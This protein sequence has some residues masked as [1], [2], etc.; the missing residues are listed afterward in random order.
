MAST[1][2]EGGYLYISTLGSFAVNEATYYME[3][4]HKLFKWE[5][6]QDD[7]WSDTGILDQGESY[8][9][10][11][12]LHN[13]YVDNGF[14]LAVLGNTVYVGKRDGHLM[15]S[16]DQGNTWNYVTAKLPFP[17][18]HFRAIVFAGNSVYVATDKGVVMS[19]N[20]ADWHIITTAKGRPL[21]M[22]RLAVDGTTV[23]GESDQ[24]IYQLNIIR[25]TWRKTWK[26]VT[27]KISHFITCLAADENTLYVGT[28]SSGVIRFRLD[29]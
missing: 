15:R 1:N 9:S 4:M 8:G 22:N 19:G 26:Q 11:W 21:V 2:I 24:K 18:D 12:H 5:P 23:Y 17:V 20:G 3:Y 6:S 16:V 7:E 10:Y 27:P 13:F 29:N 25:G 14:K 28:Y